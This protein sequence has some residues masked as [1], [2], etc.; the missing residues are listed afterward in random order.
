[1]PVIRLSTCRQQTTIANAEILEITEAAY[2][3]VSA[4]FDREGELLQAVEDG[5]FTESMLNDGWPQ[6]D[7]ES[8]E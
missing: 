3:Y 8:S 7:E 4:C 2:R 6:G 1:M 5:S